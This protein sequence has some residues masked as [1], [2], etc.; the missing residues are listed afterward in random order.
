AAALLQQ[1]IN[2][3]QTEAATAVLK[4][5]EQERRRIAV[6]LHDGVGQ[7]LSAALLHASEISKQIRQDSQPDQRSV[8]HVVHLLNDSYDEMRSISHQ[9]MPNALLKTGLA[10]AI[11]EFIQKIDHRHMHISLD[12]TGMD[13]RLDEQTETALYRITQESV[14]NVVKHAAAT[15][16]TI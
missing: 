11:R 10:S 8:D 14:N 5:E 2:K 1:E 6:E 9:M 15:K 13:E 12:I 3:Q 4:A 7:I 16:L